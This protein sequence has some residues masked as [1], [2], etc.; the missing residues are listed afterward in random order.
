MCTCGVGVTLDLIKARCLQ[1]LPYGE[2]PMSVGL[3][4]W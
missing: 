3:I 4:H 2:D 1:P